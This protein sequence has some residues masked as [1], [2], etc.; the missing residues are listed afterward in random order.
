MS[1]ILPV[2]FTEGNN[3]AHREEVSGVGGGGG[4][5]EEQRG[6]IKEGVVRAQVLA[7]TGDERAVYGLEQALHLGPRSVVRDRH[8]SRA[9]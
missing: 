7:T 6:G 2:S 4:Q 5:I 3:A 9:G 1:G 8:R